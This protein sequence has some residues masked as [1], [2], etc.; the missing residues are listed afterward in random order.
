MGNIK[1]LTLFPM[2]ILILSG[3][4]IT[5]IPIFADPPP[6]SPD[7]DIT[8]P[9]VF[10]FRITDI[11]ADKSDAENNKFTIEFEVLNWSNRVA[12]DVHISLAELND[13]QVMFVD[14]G[15][16]ADGRPLIPEDLV[17][18][19][20]VNAEDMEDTIIVNQMLDLGEDIDPDDAYTT[21]NNG[22]P[23]SRLTNDPLD[24][25]NIPNEFK[26]AVSTATNIVWEVDDTDFFPLSIPFLQSA[27]AGVASG[28]I[29]PKDLLGATASGQDAVNNLIPGVIE[30]TT[31]VDMM[32]NV[33]PVQAIDDGNNAR[34]GFTFTV[35]GFDSGE[36]FSVN[37]FLTQ[38]DFEGGSSPIGSSAFGNDFGFG[39]INFA[40]ADDGNFPGPVFVGNTGFKQTPLEFFGGVQEV[41][42]PAEIAVEFGAG[43]TVAFADSGDNIGGPPNAN[44]II[45]PTFVG[46]SVLEIDRTPVLLVAT[47]TSAAWM[48]PVIIAGIGIAIV[49]ARKY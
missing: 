45:P 36:T 16:D 43:I 44:P 39:V 18:P 3:I 32:G 38:T 13:G 40:R 8:L 23:D 27:Y 37:W 42:D 6:L 12:H 26:V 14:G 24:G 9:K 30:G 7:P 33:G 5:P 2:A 22:L 10:C 20:G 17:A 15:V 11:R 46:G 29:Q 31:T 19:A 48:I 41:P 34:D 35:D 28:G 1:V 49:I 21:Y 47:Q 4:L 25:M